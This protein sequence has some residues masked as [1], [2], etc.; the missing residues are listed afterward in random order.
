MR[1]VSYSGS[2]SNHGPSDVQ[3]IAYLLHLLSYPYSRCV[4]HLEQ[5]SAGS[6]TSLLN[7]VHGCST[8][9]KYGNTQRVSDRLKTGWRK[10]ASVIAGNR[11]PD[12]QA[13]HNHCS[14]IEAFLFTV[15]KRTS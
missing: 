13:I 2:E 8:I 14:E 5:N 4:G 9:I 15:Q 11:T 1:Q 12:L 6:G 3:P 7:A 10:Y